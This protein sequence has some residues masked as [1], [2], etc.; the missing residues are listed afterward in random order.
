MSN[1]CGERKARAS[2]V[3]GRVFTAVLRRDRQPRDA[4]SARNAG[5]A[6]GRRRSF[7]QV[8]KSGH[9][10]DG[11]PTLPQCEAGRHSGASA[12]SG[13][14]PAL[15]RR[16]RLARADRLSSWEGS[17]DAGDVGAGDTVAPLLSRLGKAGSSAERHH[18][19]RGAAARA[20]RQSEKACTCRPARIAGR[21]PGRDAPSDEHDREDDEDAGNRNPTCG[22]RGE[23]R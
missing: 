14:T 20:D 16:E 19:S 12:G 9:A 2:H 8:P 13:A 4:R 11:A 7:P 5:A 1:A 6:A 10:R 3:T 18:R 21:S 17:S 15:P 22:Q 23:D